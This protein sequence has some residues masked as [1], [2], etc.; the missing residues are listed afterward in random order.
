[1]FENFE[2]SM[3]MRKYYTNRKEKKNKNAKKNEMER[4]INTQ[5]KIK[6]FILNI[7]MKN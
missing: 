6:L 3:I 5:F 1:M 4:V 2:T 7:I